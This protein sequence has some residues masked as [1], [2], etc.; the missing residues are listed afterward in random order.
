MRVIQTEHG[1]EVR[2][3]PGAV[4]VKTYKN[5]KFNKAQLDII[6]RLKSMEKDNKERDYNV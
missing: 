5:V 4:I 2:D 6:K 1:K 3:V